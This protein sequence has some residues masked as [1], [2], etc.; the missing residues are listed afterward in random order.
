MNKHLVSAAIIGASTLS[1]TA[2]AVPDA[3]KAWEKCLGVAQAG[4]NDCGATDGSHSCSGLSKADNLDT[5]WVYVP[6]GTCDKI[7]GSVFK[8][9]PAK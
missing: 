6:Q 5:E 9:K 8:V 2:Y 3:P 4:K 1:A 7:G